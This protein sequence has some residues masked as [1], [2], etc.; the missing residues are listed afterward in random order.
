[1]AK[2]LHGD[3]TRLVM[4]GPDTGPDTL[5]CEYAVVDGDLQSTGKRADISEPDFTATSSALW[6]SAISAVETSEGI[7]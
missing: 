5:W 3:V 1:M 2:Q 6:S 7:S 4:T